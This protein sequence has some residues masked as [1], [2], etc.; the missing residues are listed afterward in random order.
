MKTPEAYT[1]PH[2]HVASNVSYFPRSAAG[3]PAS[4]S[5]AAC[6]VV[7]NERRSAGAAELVPDVCPD[8]LPGSGA[9]RAPTT[10]SGTV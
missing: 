9:S 10:G 1:V 6:D 8:V 4:S 3:S 2:V 5:L 7:A